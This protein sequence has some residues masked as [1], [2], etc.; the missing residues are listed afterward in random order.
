MEC[1]STLHINFTYKYRFQPKKNNISYFK[2]LPLI[3]HNMGNTMTLLFFFT[4]C[5]N[6]SYFLGHWLY[7]GQ[8]VYSIINI[9]FNLWTDFG[10]ILQSVSMSSCGYGHGVS[11]CLYVDVDMECLHVFMWIWTWSVSMFPCGYRHRMSPCL[12]VDTVTECLHVSMHVSM[13][14]CGYGDGVSPCGYRH[15]VYYELPGDFHVDMNSHMEISMWILTRSVFSHMEI[16]MWLITLIYK[17][18]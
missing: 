2:G 4:I 11:P 6:I 3:W 7:K 9:A 15:R 14:P 17:V 18:L 12:H 13:S 10:W 5:I 8:W 16:S 1:G